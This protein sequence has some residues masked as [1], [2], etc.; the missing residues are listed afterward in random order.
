MLE[1]KT[2]NF[3]SNPFYAGH[4][5]V[6]LILLVLAISCVPRN[7][8]PTASASSSPAQLNETGQNKRPADTYTIIN[9]G[10]AFQK[11]WEEAKDKPFNKQLEI[12]DRVIEAPHRDFYESTSWDRPYNP[13]WQQ[14]RQDLLEKRFAKLPDLYPAIVKEFDQF[15]ETIKTNVDHFQQIFSDA[16]FNI[17]IYAAISAK[18]DGR[19]LNDDQGNITMAFGMDTIAMLH[20][21]KDKK[22]FYAHELFHAY[23]FETIRQANQIENYLDQSESLL[24]SLWMEG[25]ASYISHQRDPQAPLALV[26]FS[27]DLAKVQPEDIR[28]MA[29][30]LL[31]DNANAQKMTKEEYHKVY[32]RWFAAAPEN[33]PRPDLPPRSGYL[34]GYKVAQLIHQ[35]NSL[36]EMAHWSTPRFSQEVTA[37][38]QEIAQVAQ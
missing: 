15:P 4:C 34:L 35:K 32:N 17:P 3:S 21:D 22:I 33:R 1:L 38:L 13:Q 20:T 25:L 2:K 27:E 28:W 36:D 29:Q 12:W 6:L 24:T 5:L 14:R 19:V 30:E 23:H 18:Y 37:A 31:K 9:L 10:P 7:G 26:L 8:S 11:F 16:Y